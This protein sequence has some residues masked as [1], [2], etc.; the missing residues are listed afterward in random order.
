MQRLEEEFAARGKG[1]QFGR[2]KC[3]VIGD[4]AGAG[5][6]DV[7]AALGITEAA[8]KMAAHR[9]RQ[10]YRQLLREEIV[11]TVAG[12]EEVDDEIRSLFAALA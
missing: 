11:Q 10:R 4:H 8:A 2:L 5:Y 12:P 9:M 3:F 7:A 6:A 1:E